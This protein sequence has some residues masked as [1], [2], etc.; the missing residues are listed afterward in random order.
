[1]QAARPPTATAPPTPW[2]P[3]RAL[4]FIALG[5]AFVAGTLWVRPTSGYSS[6]QP[7]LILLLGVTLLAAIAASSGAPT[8]PRAF[9]RF[10]S[11]N[12]VGAIVSAFLS[13]AGSEAGLFF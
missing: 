5:S 7:L 8:A 12:I 11:V 6:S 10:L 4:P 2:I 13:I 1:M 9:R 3:T